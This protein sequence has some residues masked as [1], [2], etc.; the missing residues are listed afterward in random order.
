MDVEEMLKLL[1]VKTQSRESIELCW[2]MDLQAFNM[3]ETG[4]NQFRS[5]RYIYTCVYQLLLD[6]LKYKKLDFELKEE[7]KKEVDKID[8]NEEDKNYRDRF[9]TGLE[10][11]LLRYGRYDLVGYQRIP[12]SSIEGMAKDAYLYELSGNYDK[13]IKYYTKLGFVER[14][15]KCNKKLSN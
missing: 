8:L 4:D 9:F 7:I 15:K 5:E 3:M 13:A 1:G 2:E 10:R 11:V 6:E 12:E 14:I